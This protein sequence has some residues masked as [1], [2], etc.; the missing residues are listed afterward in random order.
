M[1]LLSP[2]KNMKFDQTTNLFEPS[3]P[4]F[5]KETNYLINKLRE[6]TKTQ[7]KKMMKLSDNLS[8]LNY[9]RYKSFRYLLKIIIMPYLFLTEILSKD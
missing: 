8:N 4:Y 7:I 9:D 1:I 2:A 6:L 3:S 5:S